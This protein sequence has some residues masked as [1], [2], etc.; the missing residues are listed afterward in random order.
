MSEE[1]PIYFYSVNGNFGEF[2]NFSDYGFYE[3]DVYWKTVEHFYQSNK[4]ESSSYSEKIRKSSTP[5]M[6]R[7]LGQSRKVPLRKDWDTIKNEIMKIAVKNKFESNKTILDLLLFTDDKEIVESSPYDYYWG[8]GKDGS[9]KNMLGKI[10]M[11]FRDQ[12]EFEE[13]YIKE[14]SGWDNFESI[15]KYLQKEFNAKVIDKLDGIVVRIWEFQIE[16]FIFTFKHHDDFGNFFYTKN[17]SNQSIL[18][19]IVDKIEK[20]LS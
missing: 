1:I 19:K 14:A 3:N 16:D 18:K 5:K 20:K 4:F 2:S 17:V 12:Y 8:C 13:F 15:S 7:E 9:G 11:E 10:L 6:A